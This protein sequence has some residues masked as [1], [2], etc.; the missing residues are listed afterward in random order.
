MKPPWWA[1]AARLAFY[2]IGAVMVWFLRACPLSVLSLATWA[3]L[4]VSLAV[5]V[6]T[7]D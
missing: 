7:K 4:A 3:L 6:G 1:T 5:V 2:A